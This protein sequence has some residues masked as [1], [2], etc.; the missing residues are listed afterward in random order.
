VTPATTSTPDFSTASTAPVTAPKTT[1]DA[2]AP[3]SSYMPGSTGAASGY[4]T[5]TES[6]TTQGSFYR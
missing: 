6:P 2:G 1:Q 3:S 4:P 5:G